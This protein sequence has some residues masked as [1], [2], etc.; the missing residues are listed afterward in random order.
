MKT[1]ITIEASAWKKA[2]ATLNTVVTTR[3]ALPILGDVVLR[4]NPETKLFQL[5]ASDG[6]SWLTID[7][8]HDAATPWVKI[9][10][11]DT[12]DRFT[13]VALPFARLKEA[14][15]LLPASMLLSVWFNSESHQMTVDYQIGKF[16]IPFDD[17]VEFPVCPDVVETAGGENRPDPV[18]RFTLSSDQLLPVMKQARI[19]AARDELRPIMNGECLDVFADRLAVVATDGHTLFKD[20]LDVGAGWLDYG[21]FPTFDAASGQPGS[22]RIIVSKTV[23]G[24]VAAAFTGAESIRL[25]ADTQR[26]ELKADG[27]RLVSRLIDGKYPNYDSV[28]PKDSPIR[29]VVG[30]EAVRQALRRL[31]LFAN[32]ASNLAVMRREG[33]QFIIE[34]SDIDFASSGSEELRIIE[35]DAFLPADFKIGFKISAMLTLLDA[36]TTENVVL[37]FSDANHAFLMKPEDVRSSRTLLQMPMLINE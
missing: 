30:R 17:A 12:R 4:V 8:R 32:S 35:G 31:S 11:D 2:L 6:E 29:V 37:F 9:I 5:T 23:L 24:A 19:C 1:K 26:V 27:V 36:I 28:I 33:E 7:C 21:H 20:I 34:T 10:E 25:T 22:A 3:N 14:V 16:S 18:C 15:G 13:Q